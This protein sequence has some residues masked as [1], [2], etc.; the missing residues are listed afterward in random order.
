MTF[1]T[2]SKSSARAESSNDQEE[3]IDGTNAEVQQTTRE[4]DSDDDSDSV[5]SV[6]SLASTESQRRRRLLPAVSPSKKAVELITVQGHFAEVIYDLQ[7]IG[8]ADFLYVTETVPQENRQDVIFGEWFTRNITIIH[9]QSL[10]PG[11]WIFQFDSKFND[12]IY[13]L[14]TAIERILCVTEASPMMFKVVNIMVNTRNSREEEY[15]LSDSYFYIAKSTIR[16]PRLLL[17]LSLDNEGTTLPAFAFLA[18]AEAAGEEVVKAE[19]VKHSIKMADIAN[20]AM[21]STENTRERRVEE[22][23]VKAGVGNVKRVG[24]LGVGGQFQWH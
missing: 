3:H 11:L 14:Y 24:T 19:R 12:T 6:V 7:L 10:R 8:K 17:S 18:N 9:Q 21:T 13:M 4:D 5:L 15:V 23:R 2:F 22:A 20:A 16:V 1:L